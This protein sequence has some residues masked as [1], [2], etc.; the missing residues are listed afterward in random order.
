[1]DLKITGWTLHFNTINTFM[2]HYTKNTINTKN[3]MFHCYIHLAKSQP[4]N[5]RGYRVYMHITE[6]RMYDQFDFTVDPSLPLTPKNI[7]YILNKSLEDM[8]LKLL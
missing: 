1:M 5:I 7:E 3:R 8:F 6:F 2:L 4:K